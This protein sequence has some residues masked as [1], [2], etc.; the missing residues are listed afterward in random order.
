MNPSRPNIPKI[1][2]QTALADDLAKPDIAGS[3]QALQDANPGYDYRFF[4][5]ATARA[6][7]LDRV[8]DAVAQKL[9][10]LNPAYSVLFADLF[11]YLVIYEYGGVY[12]DIKS[13]SRDPLDQIIQP[14]DEIILAQWR[15]GLGQTYEGYGLHQELQRVP[16]GEVVQWFLMARP[17]HPILA[18]VL[19]RVYDN[20]IDYSPYYFG[21]GRNG[22][23]RT[24]GPI[25]FTLA[26]APMLVNHDIRF[27]DLNDVG[28]IYSIYGEDWLGHTNPGHYAVQSDPVF[29]PPDQGWTAIHFG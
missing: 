5:D 22:V 8:P 11:R 16:G 24:S 17:K 27:V 20:I 2:F 12:F 1:I 15:N 4:D 26:V 29:P 21:Y 6:F 25:A 28:L 23:L 10:T 3:V 9:E 7:V 13:T 14:D 18:R 19:A